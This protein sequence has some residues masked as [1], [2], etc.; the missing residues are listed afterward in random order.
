MVKCGRSNCA[1]G[2]VINVTQPLCKSHFI[3]G[4]ESKVAA[5]IGKYGLVSEKDRI[6]VACSGGKDS[7][8]VLYLLNKWFGNVTALAIDEGIPGYRNATLEDLRSF[9]SRNKIPL[10]TSSYKQA[11]GFS[12][13]EALRRVAVLPCNICGTLRRH[14]L[15][16]GA[17]GFTRIA[18]GHNLDDEAQSVLMN[19]MK[20]NIGLAAR[21][22]P[23]SG[24][25]ADV[26]FV[27]RVKPLYF[28]LEKEVAAYAFL[29]GFG[30]RFNECPHSHISFRASVRDFLNGLEQE[31]PGSKQNIVKN[32]VRLLP[33]LKEAY[34]A[35]TGISHCTV[36]GEQASGEVCKACSYVDSLKKQAAIDWQHTAKF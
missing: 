35:E 16:R 30:I 2:A 5:T 1:E 31:M 7:T 13:D 36:C 29:M 20:S 4:F 10:K 19:I 28:C 32:F 14:L 33:K 3:S 27:P 21:L 6:I 26:K 24:V 25:A 17:R 12:L 11:F 34:A 15:N 23:V 8:T 9:C 18:T 22:G